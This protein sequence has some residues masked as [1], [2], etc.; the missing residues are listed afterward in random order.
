MER[1]DFRSLGRAAQEA[2]RARANY[3]VLQTGK[4]QGDAAEA[5]GV[6]R[7]VVNRW[8]QRYTASGADSLLDGRRLSSRQGQGRLTPLE[9]V[10]CRGGSGTSARI[11]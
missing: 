1:R 4:S 8:V 11:N 5:V 2:L 10:G 3:L 6:S 9:R 7:Q